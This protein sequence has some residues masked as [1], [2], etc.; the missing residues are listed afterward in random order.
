[1]IRA[2]IFDID[3]VLVDSE[4]VY[5]QGELDYLK[6]KYPHITYEDMVPTVGM[7]SKMFRKHFSDLLGMNPESEEF[8][9]V[10]KEMNS[11]MKVDYPSIMRKDV[12]EVLKKLS[13]MKMKLAV[14]S[15]GDYKDVEKLLKECNIFD[16]FEV[17]CTGDMFK[18]SK[19]N[20]DIYLT[21][22]KKL[23]VKPEECFV[24]EDSMMGIEAAKTAGATVCAMIETRFPFSQEKAD[25][26]VSSLSE[27]IPIISKQYKAV[28]FDVDGTLTDFVYHKMPEGNR[29]VLNRLRE[30]GIKLFISTGRAKIEMKLAHML[31]DEEF[32]GYIYAN[33]QQ[34]E[35]HGE[36][37]DLHYF[38]DEQ[39]SLIKRYYAENKV[40]NVYYDTEGVFSSYI[41]DK[42]KVVQDSI[43]CD[44]PPL[45]DWNDYDDL[46]IT[47]MNSV[48][49]D[50]QVTELCSMVKGIKCGRWCEY[51][52]D[53]MTSDS[54]KDIGV[55][56]ICEAMGIDPFETL[57]FGDGE[58]DIP[59]L[60]RTGI[61]VAMGNS[62][63]TVKENVT[64]VTDDFTD[65]GIY[66][67]LVYFGIL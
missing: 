47:S 60:N 38:N 15:S 45:K 41:D 34:S 57:S 54:G 2:V 52:V 46:K 36:T 31:E 63:D 18:E 48:L 51:C 37:V 62:S 3:G 6:D 44:V 14:A 56:K 55:E 42:L 27:I 12:K 39:L 20:P 33:G 8:L 9:N 43:G 1:M 67:A 65:N 49:N 13:Q 25:Y 5:L 59:M 7:S 40:A 16:S 28:F 22:M 10:I 53:L 19:P 58:N 50:E 64:Y 30:K 29:I 61:G 24:V 23:G 17:I 66:N 32:D 35:I 4:P 26:H 21:T 11:G